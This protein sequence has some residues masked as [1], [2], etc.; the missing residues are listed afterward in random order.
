MTDG[1]ASDFPQARQLIQ[2]RNQTTRKKDGQQEKATRHFVTSLTAAAAGPAR[3]AEII[4]GHWTSESRHWQRDACWGEDRCRLR[5][6]HAACALG[7]LRTTL[8]SLL[9]WAG[10]AS[11]PEV[12]ED[13]SAHLPLGLNW[14]NR[15]RFKR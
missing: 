14:L 11:L 8:Q 6:A 4:R 12:F 9:R 15:R 10:R 5:D 3:L 1:E 7:L 2:A 13:V